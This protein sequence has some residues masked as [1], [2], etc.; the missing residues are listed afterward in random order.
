MTPI[1]VPTAQ[2]LIPRLLL[3]ERGLHWVLEWQDPLP[4]T[5]QPPGSHPD[6]LKEEPLIGRNDVHLDLRRVATISLPAP[7]FRPSRLT[8]S[9]RDPPKILKQ[10]QL[11]GP[12][13]WL[14][15]YITCHSILW[16]L[17]QRLIH[18]LQAQVLWRGQ[19]EQLQGMESPKTGPAWENWWTRGQQVPGARGCWEPPHTSLL[20]LSAPISWVQILAP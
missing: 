15:P 4:H 17:E 16:T 14:F 20:R 11:E 1:P 8:C 7:G 3:Q 5:A 6:V 18:A 13:W 19:E 10:P 2:A 12:S 9:N